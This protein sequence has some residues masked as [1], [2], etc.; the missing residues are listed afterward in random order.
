MSCLRIHSNPPAARRTNR[1]HKVLFSGAFPVTIGLR[2]VMLALGLLGVQSRFARSIGATSHMK[3]TAPRSAAELAR[4]VKVAAGREPAD[5]VLKGGRVVNVHAAEICEVDVAIAGNRIAGL[6]SYDGRENVKLGGQ[7]VCPGFIDAHVHI[8]SSMLSVPEFASVVAAH[9]TTAVVADPHEI[10]NVMG[11]EGIRYILRSSKHSPINVYLMLSSCVPASHLESAGA[12]LDA[13]DLK[14][15]LSDPWVLGLAEVMNYPG[16]INCEPEIMD[17]LELFQATIIDGHAPGLS[18]P[19]LMAYAAA[20][21]RSDHECTTIPEAAEKLATGMY[22]MIREGSVARNLDDLLGLVKPETAHRFMFVTDDKHVD[23]LMQEGQID[24]MVKRAVARGM[25]PTLAVQLAATNAAR[26]FEL[27]SVGA[28]TPGRL[29][30]LTILENFETCKATRV[31]KE[32]QLVAADGECIKKVPAPKAT[33]GLRSTINIQWLKPDDF[34]IPAPSP[35]PRVHV[36]SVVPD[37][38]HTE[39]SVEEAPVES[40]MVVAAP[41]RDLCKLALLE[42]HQA[43]GRIGLGLVRGFGLREGAL[44]SSVAHDAHNLM[45]V[46]TNDADLLAAAVQLVKI[47]GGLCVVRDGRTLADLPLSIG[48]LMSEAPAAEVARQLRRV[49][50]AARELGCA[51]KRPFMGLS[52]LS[53]SVIGSLKVTDRGLVDGNRFE[54]IDL[55][56]E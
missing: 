18:G 10:A 42:R 13:S 54:L 44:A 24:Y 45:I 40:G 1:S 46:G 5:L 21:V 50:E 34:A 2:R 16:V 4:L 14:P 23:D 48:G 56:V 53:L 37:Q 15:L 6:G 12:E 17:K 33:V 28:V 31:Y 36:I 38:V 41:T 35:G 39:R 11:T 7:Y 26:Y 43:S 20:G 55:F 9:G 49:R 22:I 51:L 25:S 32:G 52:F 27:R 8:E 19:D 30:T 29:A 47:R 3:E